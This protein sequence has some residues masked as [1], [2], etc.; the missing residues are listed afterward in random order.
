MITTPESL[1]SFWFGDELDSP[2]AVAERTQLWFAGDA[3]FDGRVRERFADLPA[4]AA[5]GRLDTWR[6]EARSSLALVL[7]LD[8]L[9]RNLYRDGAQCFAYDSLA[10][11]LALA[12]I[13][14]G[15]DCEL[16]AL[17]ASFLYLP[18]EH[19]EDPEAQERCV[20]LFRSL[21]DRAPPALRSHFE[22]FLGY[23]IRHRD[24]IRRFGRFPHRNA[25]LGR[26]STEAER[27][28]LESGGETFGGASGS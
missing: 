10:Y 8:Q 13:E 14:R 19:A 18:L 25:V 28:Y 22:S 6:K 7:A 1:L 9:P 15:F 20:S 4:L 27:E 21:Q 2:E 23:A 3:S 11:E 24:V 17:E 12:A 26:A 5:A 16:T